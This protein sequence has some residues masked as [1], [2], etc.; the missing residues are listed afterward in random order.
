MQLRREIAGAAPDGE[1]RFELSQA[2]TILT[3]TLVKVGRHRDARPHA[4]EA[5][6]RARAVLRH[7]GPVHRPSYFQALCLLATV[8]Q[9][10]G[11]IGPA[12]ET[13]Y[14]TVE[15]GRDLMTASGGA[16]RSALMMA[17]TSL[18][19]QLTALGRHREARAS[20]E[21]LNRLRQ[22]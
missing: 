13:L 9:Q 19:L 14:E 3:S 6:A 17:L 20:V 1:A 18:S 4:E 7:D 12:V 10:T 16:D 22:G 8:Q 2:A 11:E 15:V 5:V 21:E